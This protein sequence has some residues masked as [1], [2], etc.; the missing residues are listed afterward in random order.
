[1]TMFDVPAITSGAMGFNVSVFIHESTP[2]LWQCNIRRTVKPPPYWTYYLPFQAARG[3]TRRVHSGSGV[4]SSR[5]SCLG[6]PLQPSPHHRNWESF[7]QPRGRDC[8]QRM[9]RWQVC[10]LGVVK[11][12]K[13]PFLQLSTD[14]IT[15][16]NDQPRIFPVASIWSCTVASNLKNATSMCCSKF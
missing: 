5:Q 11:F 16:V 15:K 10:S 4:I 14:L 9:V 6:K 13:V 7:G 12:L 8:L 2:S 1:M 3:H